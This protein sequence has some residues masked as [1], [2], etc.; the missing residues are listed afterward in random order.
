MPK[1][2][3][4][5]AEAA[6]LCRAAAKRL[7][8]LDAPADTLIGLR[9]RI[10]T[11]A[12]RLDGLQSKFFVR[13]APA[14]RYTSGCLEAARA[15]EAALADGAPSEALAATLDALETA[16]TTLEDRANAAGNMTIT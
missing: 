11:A 7:D 14:V 6:E 13:M 5:V 1:G 15:V 9:S 3:D 4:Q 16:T 12:E 2:K 8:T 10:E